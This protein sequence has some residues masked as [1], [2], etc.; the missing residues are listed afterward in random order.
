[1][2]RSGQA[3][4]AFIPCVITG[5]IIHQPSMHAPAYAKFRLGGDVGEQGVIEDAGQAVGRGDA[6]RTPLS[7]MQ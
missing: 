7:H 1:M 4:P 3:R 2:P 5:C 6:V